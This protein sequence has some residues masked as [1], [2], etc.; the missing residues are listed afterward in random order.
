MLLKSG[1]EQPIRPLISIING[2]NLNRAMNGS[3]MYALRFDP[4]RLY[5]DE[6]LNWSLCTRS[7]RSY[8]TAS[9]DPSI[10]HRAFSEAF[11]QASKC[12]VFHGLGWADII[13]YLIYLTH[14]KFIINWANSIQRLSIGV[15][16]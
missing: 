13:N 6:Q 2:S 4:N 12:E 15:L 14:H 3:N 10:F 5:R 8:S 11:P 16:G 7:I 1:A 9:S